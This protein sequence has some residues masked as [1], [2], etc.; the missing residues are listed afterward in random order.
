M[1]E[2]LKMGNQGALGSLRASQCI[3]HSQDHFYCYSYFVNRI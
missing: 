1:Q 2:E 3:L